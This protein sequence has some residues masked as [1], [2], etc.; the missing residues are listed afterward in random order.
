MTSVKTSQS[1]CKVCLLSYTHMYVD[2]ICGNYR[3]YVSLLLVIFEKLI[4]L[5][6]N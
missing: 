6:S 5:V 4:K 1:F 3:M 2:M